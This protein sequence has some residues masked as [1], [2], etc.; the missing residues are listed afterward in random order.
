MADL[1]ARKQL[2]NTIKA[3]AEEEGVAER[4]LRRWIAISALI[5]VFNIARADGRLPPFLVKGGFALE[6]RFKSGARASRDID[7]VIEAQKRKLLDAAVEAM[8]ID[9]S[10]FTFKIRGNPQEREHSYKF[11]VSASYKGQDWSTFEVELV[12]GKVID[13]EMVEPYPI[14]EF[15]LER[16]SDVPCMNVYEQVAQK[17]HAVTDPDENRPRDLV[18]IFLIG[19]Q[20]ELE[21]ENLRIAAETVF[22]QRAKHPWPSPIELR[23]GWAVAIEEIVDRNQLGLTVDGILDGVRAIVVKLLGVTP[24]MN[25]RYHF[26]VLSAQDHIPN[27]TE[28]ALVADD[29]YATLQRMTGQEGWRLLQMIDYPGRDRSRALLAVLEKPNPPAE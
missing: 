24:R 14:D 19:Q 18:D 5:E 11:E 15:G 20:I 27:A 2:A 21:F 7:F 1:P 4:R 25:Y 13:P 6:A 8:R 29:G 12:A 22:V 3:A 26:L 16:P 17:L 10:G 28:P 23:E 9:W